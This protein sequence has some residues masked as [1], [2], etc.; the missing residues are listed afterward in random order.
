MRNNFVIIMTMCAT[1]KE[2]RKIA[3][4]ILKKR[5]AACTNIISGVESKF[6]W[7]G[8]IDS[9]SEVMLMAKTVL[10]NY[11]KLEAEIRRLHSYDVPEIVAIPIAAGS[12][13]YL[14]WIGESVK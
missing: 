2:A 12:G 10:A 4:A 5:L 3:D 9:A 1:G 11:K 7:K 13:D 14:D 6:W 8:K